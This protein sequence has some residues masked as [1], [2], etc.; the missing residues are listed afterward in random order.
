VEGSGVWFQS[1]KTHYLAGWP[2]GT[3]LLEIFGTLAAE[4]GLQVRSLP[5]GLRLRR[6]GN[7]QFAFNYAPGEADISGL[8]PDGASL[9]LGELCLPP[10]GVAAWTVA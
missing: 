8:I 7:I 4:C 6:H 10:A 1:G 3:L 2:D 9:L 5:Q